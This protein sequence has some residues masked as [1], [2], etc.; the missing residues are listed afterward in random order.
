MKILI[1]IFSFFPK[2]GVMFYYG[3][4]EYLVFS[5]KSVRVIPWICLRGTNK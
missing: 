2:N 1:K 4:N 5:Y 3:K